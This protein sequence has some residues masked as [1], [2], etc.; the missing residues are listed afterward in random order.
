MIVDFRLGRFLSGLQTGVAVAVMLFV[1]ELL[2]HRRCWLVAMR[3]PFSALRRLDFILGDDGRLTVG[4]DA[5]GAPCPSDCR[6]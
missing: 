4:R 2:I 6:H 5:P 3:M 1:P